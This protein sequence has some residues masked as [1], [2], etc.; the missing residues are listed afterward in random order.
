VNLAPLSS[1]GRRLIAYAFAKSMEGAADDPSTIVIFSPFLDLPLAKS[2]TFG[3]S[4]IT[5]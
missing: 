3:A 1:F 4:D 2:L 5:Q